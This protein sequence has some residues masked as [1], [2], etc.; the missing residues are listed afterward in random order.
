MKIDPQSLE[1]EDIVERVSQAT[2]S[3][4]A[5]TGFKAAV[6]PID[7]LDITTMAKVM[8]AA[9]ALAAQEAADKGLPKYGLTG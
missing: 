4:L 5:Q 2:W 9:T 7:Q 8:R 3:P 6:R 1:S